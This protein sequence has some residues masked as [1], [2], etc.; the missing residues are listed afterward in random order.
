MED[1]NEEFKQLRDYVDSCLC[2]NLD[3]FSLEKLK[4]GFTAAMASQA[5][6]KYKI[7][8]VSASFVRP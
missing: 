8:K 5:C 6:E 3:S 2:S 1:P 7:N 4:E